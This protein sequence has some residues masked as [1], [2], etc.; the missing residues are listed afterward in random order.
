MGESRKKAPIENSTNRILSQTRLSD[1]RTA[2]MSL[3][4]SS[5]K[6]ADLPDMQT[7][8]RS[9]R[10]ILWPARAESECTYVATSTRVS[11]AAEWMWPTAI[12]SWRMDI[13]VVWENRRTT[14]HVQSPFFYSPTRER[15]LA[16]LLRSLC[17][18]R[19][20][21]PLYSTAR[22][23]LATARNLHRDE[24]QKGRRRL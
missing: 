9:Q 12:N 18:A 19:Y 23:F 6:I 1:R 15:S 5:R 24:R 10:N 3:C 8:E 16:L 14:H 2:P 7:M 21:K 13:R 20:V 4:F 11:V 17:S 22:L